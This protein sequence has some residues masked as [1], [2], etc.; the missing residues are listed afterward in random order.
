MKP[1]TKLVSNKLLTRSALV[2]VTTLS[3]NATHAESE[4]VAYAMS[5]LE[6]STGAKDIL[7]GD[8]GQVIENLATSTP[9]A[10]G[11]F[12]TQTN[13]CVA[14][15]KSGDFSSA[16]H[17]CDSA[18]AVTRKALAEVRGSYSAGFTQRSLRRELAVALSNRGVLR[19]HS[20]ETELAGQDFVEASEQKSGLLEPYANLSRFV[21]A[22]DS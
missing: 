17:A 11:K 8:Y 15:T 2:L 6:D 5:V 13:L 20:G 10:A 18:V 1:L 7:R 12:A 3:I 19:V 14:Y 22:S 16:E 9:R 21:E 4:S